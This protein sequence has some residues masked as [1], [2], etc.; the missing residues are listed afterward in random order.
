MIKAILIDDSKN[1]IDALNIKLA[2][3][4]PDVKVIASYTNPRD[5]INELD[6]HA[7]DIVFLDVEM[8]GLSGFSLL[9]ELGDIS[10]DIIFVTAHNHYAVNAI[11]A[12]ALDYLE[13]PVNVKLLK[14]AMERLKEKRNKNSANNHVPIH[15]QNLLDIFNTLQ[16][17]NQKNNLLPLST[18][19]GILMADVNDIVWV[20]SLSN[21][22]KFYFHEN[23]NVVL[24][25][26]TMGEFEPF[27][28]NHDFFRIH[29]STIINIKYIHKYQRGEGGT[30]VMKDG[31]TLEVST[32]KKQEFL[33]RLMDNG[34]VQFE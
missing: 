11:R 7:P 15:Q 33:N 20:E 22:T 26:K 32:R 24:V 27:L 16:K 25:S 12:K 13:K 5:F 10:F 9:K 31:T 21:Y 28:K 3:H 23:K 8:P 18:T 19:D 29:R 6:L 1:A 14:E 4:C 30:V 34:R 17:A 2:T